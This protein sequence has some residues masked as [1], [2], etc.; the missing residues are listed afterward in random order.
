MT[1]LSE[2][3]ASYYLDRASLS[4]KRVYQANIAYPIIPI[5][6]KIV[7]HVLGK[8]QK[9]IEN[10]TICMTSPRRVAS[11]RQTYIDTYYTLV[12]IVFD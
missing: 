10:G 4:R 11:T 6:I 5:S 1:K 2:S 12:C 7:V 8:F 9:Y 3:I